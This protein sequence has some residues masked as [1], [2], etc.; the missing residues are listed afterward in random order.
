MFYNSQC[1][2]CGKSLK[3]NEGIN[4]GIIYP[5]TWCNEECRDKYF[6]NIREENLKYYPPLS[7]SV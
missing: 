6:A 7:G 3:E 4:G 2:N 1:D 5:N